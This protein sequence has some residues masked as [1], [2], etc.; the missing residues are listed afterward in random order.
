MKNGSFLRDIC[1]V[2]DIVTIKFFKKN[3]HRINQSIIRTTYKQ[4]ESYW[5]YIAEKELKSFDTFFI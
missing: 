1:F 4:E 5:M 3:W 2:N